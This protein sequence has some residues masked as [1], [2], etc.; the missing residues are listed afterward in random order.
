MRHLKSLIVSVVGLFLVIFSQSQVFAQ[1]R[2]S[3][4]SIIKGGTVVTMDASRRVIDNGAIAL[5][6][7]RIV[8]V[9][10]AADI[11]REYTARESIDGHGK[12]I[13]PGLINGHTTVPMTLFRGV[14]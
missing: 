6:A 3:V 9:G 12:V 14:G 11:D 5:K 13:I 7:G 10:T 1:H 4:D 2:M 8:A